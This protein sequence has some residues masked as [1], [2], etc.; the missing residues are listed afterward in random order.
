MYVTVDVELV[1]HGVIIYSVR[2]DVRGNI[3][4]NPIKGFLHA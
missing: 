3:N 1:T 4:T 2:E